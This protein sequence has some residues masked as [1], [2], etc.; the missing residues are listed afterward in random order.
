VSCREQP[1]SRDYAHILP[2]GPQPITAVLNRSPRV[3]SSQTQQNSLP[4]LTDWSHISSAERAGPSRREQL[5]WPLK[6]AARPESP[7][8]GKPRPES[9]S[10]PMRP[11]G[12]E[13]CCMGNKQADPRTV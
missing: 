9:K 10:N 8:S 4:L 12:E 11:T 6:N 13:T 7:I 5:F 3:E 1:A 2:R